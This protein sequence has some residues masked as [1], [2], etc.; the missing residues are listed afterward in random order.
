MEL[1]KYSVKNL[2]IIFYIVIPVLFYIVPLYF[3]LS[4]GE[5]KV[6]FY[7][8]LTAN[9]ETVVGVLF[10]HII[11][12]LT[13]YYA[14]K[15]SNYY[16]RLN[17]KNIVLDFTTLILF[18]C[19][20]FS[21][22]IISMI[23]WSLFFISLANT[24]LYHITYFLMFLLGTANLIINGERVL[25][26]MVL[27]AWLFPY[28]TK[29][30]IRQLFIFSF[31]GLLIL[32]YILQPLKYGLLPF[33]N[34]ENPIQ[35]SSYLIQHLF[36][37]YL[38][39]FLSYSIDFSASSLFFEFIPFGKSISGE[40]GIVERLAMEGLPQDMI[41][42]GARLGSNSAM[43]F[44]IIGIPILMVMFLIIKSNMWILKSRMLINSYLMYFV[45]QGPYFIRRSFASYTIDIII[46][47]VLV[48]II[49][50]IILVLKNQ[51]KVGVYE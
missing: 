30:S 22:G 31:V 45:L 24:K 32:V 25:L 1:E 10:G 28:L 34:F 37:I 20:I 3:L 44:S 47:T 17:R 38:T 16:L 8:T 41:S 12:G 15:S 19:A 23:V 2:L 42:E 51:R 36:P 49:S 6:H 40:I 14:L 27:I 11:L 35:A 7:S 21:S 5:F 9:F 26:V 29:M 4:F 43:Y 48:I 50:F 33:S 13:I 39:S 18:T 46:I